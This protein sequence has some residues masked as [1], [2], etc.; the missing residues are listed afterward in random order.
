MYI[1]KFLGFLY[2]TTKSVEIVILLENIYEI[3]NKI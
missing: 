2:N 3:F 1:D